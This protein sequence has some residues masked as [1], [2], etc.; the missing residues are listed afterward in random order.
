MNS[1]FSTKKWNKIFLYL[2]FICCTFS[3]AGTD[4]SII[5]LYLL[6][7]INWIWVRPFS[8][9]ENPLFWVI[10]FF[11]ATAVLSGLLNAY[12]TEHLMALRTNWRLLLPLLL[13]VKLAE[14]DEEKLL[15]IFFVFVLLIST[16]GI[17]QYFNGADFLRAESQQMTTPFSS[18]SSS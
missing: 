18:G 7:M 12:E 14:V 16:Y 6:T 8:Q 1:F 2:L 4:A 11:V 17:I 3:I 5:I 10:L 9:L 13:A 15:W